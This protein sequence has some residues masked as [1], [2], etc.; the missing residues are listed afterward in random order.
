MR[1]FLVIL[2]A[3]VIGMFVA[4]WMISQFAEVPIVYSSW[5]TGYCMRVESPNSN[6]N[7]ENLPNKYQH[8]WVE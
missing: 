5:K 3:A 4:A 1:D 2:G 6:D 7:C 8:A